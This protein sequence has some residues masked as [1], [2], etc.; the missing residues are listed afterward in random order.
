MPESLD[1]SLTTSYTYNSRISKVSEQMSI[2]LEVYNHE[3]IYFTGMVQTRQFYLDLKSDSIS[4]KATSL[5]CAIVTSQ[6][7]TLFQR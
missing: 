7:V 2:Q 5:L 3:S 6:L 4:M 1:V